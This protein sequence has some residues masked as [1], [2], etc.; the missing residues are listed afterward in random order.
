MSELDAFRQPDLTMTIDPAPNGYVASVRRAP[1]N[2]TFTVAFPSKINFNSI[3]TQVV[4]LRS[5]L[6]KWSRQYNNLLDSAKTDKLTCDHT[7]VRPLW[8]FLATSGRALYSEFFN[9]IKSGSAPARLA[10]TIKNLPEGSHLSIDS[11]DLVIPWGLLYDGELPAAD[12]KNYLE[13]LLQHFWGFRYEIEL[14]PPYSGGDYD[15]NDFINLRPYLDNSAATR[16]TFSINEKSDEDYQTTQMTFF[17]GLGKLFSFSA[18]PEVNYRR[19]D[20]IKSMMNRQE[21]HHLF[22]F[23]CHHAKGEGVTSQYGSIDFKERTRIMMEGER[24]GVIE[25]QELKQLTRDQKLLN[26]EFPP[27]IFLNACDSGQLEMGD[28][29]GFMEYFL[30]D[31]RSSDYIGTE[32]NV[33]AL[34][35][36]KFGQDFVNQFFTGKSVGTILRELSRSFAT[37]YNN[38][39]GLY[40]NLFGYADLHL[41]KE[42]EKK[43]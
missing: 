17:S 40:Y 43:S 15:D 36:D 37:N 25:L 38:P 14:Q 13:T 18:D 11:T 41:S 22:Y 3:Q 31:L 4:N 19:D 27:L 12:D 8:D 23:F 16:L 26:F 42:V 2:R 35:A 5:E 24:G 34:F 20:V 32:A 28:P 9:I 30:N 39:F 7:A 33:P 29:S 10:Q 21:P 1:K 6:T